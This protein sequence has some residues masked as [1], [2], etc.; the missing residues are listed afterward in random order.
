MKVHMICELFFEKSV[1]FVSSS[2][3]V[4]VTFDW[5]ERN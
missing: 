2:S 3:K 1:K 4:G 5:Y